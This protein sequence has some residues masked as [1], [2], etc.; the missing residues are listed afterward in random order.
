MQYRPYVNAPAAPR[1]G[2][3][4]HTHANFAPGCTKCDTRMAHRSARM[5]DQRIASTARTMRQA[6]AR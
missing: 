2:T 5:V 1:Q 3:P 4:H 6:Y